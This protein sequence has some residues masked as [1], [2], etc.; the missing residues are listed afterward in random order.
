MHNDFT[1]VAPGWII[2]HT[3]GPSVLVGWKTNGDFD[4]IPVVASKERGVTELRNVIG[5][6]PWWVRMAVESDY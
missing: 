1:P 6:D 4:P 2:D 5:N 3:G